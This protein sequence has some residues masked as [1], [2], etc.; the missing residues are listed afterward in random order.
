MRMRLAIISDTHFGDSHCALITRD[1]A[2]NLVR[3]A[4][5]RQ[6]VEAV[7]QVK[8]LVMAGDVFDF[9]VT[10]YDRAY[11]CARNFFQWLKD[12]GV[13]ER[14]VYLPGN[15]DADMWY[16]VLHQVH[17]I[18]SV[19]QGDVPDAF[20]HSVPAIIDDRQGADR[21]MLYGVKMREDSGLPYGGLFLDSLTKPATNFNF[22]FPNL[23]IVTDEETVLVTHGQY[24][25]P[26]WS[27]LGE[28]I[29]EVAAG[30]L[31]PGH[32]GHPR[33]DLDVDEIV[34]LNFPLNQLAC[35]GVGQAG[36]LTR[37]IVRPV[38][39][40][41][42]KRE[43]GRIERYLKGIERIVDRK[44]EFDKTL[45]GW[46]KEKW[47]DKTIGYAREWLMQEITRVE[48]ARNNKNFPAEEKER[49]KRYYRACL[50][51]IGLINETAQMNIPA[52]GRII[53]G[54]THE[55][56]GWQEKDPF[57]LGGI[58]QD[59]TDGR[60]TLHNTGGWVFGDEQ[61]NGFCAAEVFLYETGAGFSSVRIT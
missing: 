59:G 32:D 3:G 9:S 41:L 5:Y 29:T 60:V 46:I 37:Q 38:Q 35:T 47:S 34:Q 52:P 48:P 14:I 22:A 39:L 2:G 23:Y 7:G 6:L 51:E 28:I 57:R 50:N 20:R 8:Y 16:I 40:E 24:F 26:Y 30:D 54:H 56:F 27:C 13:A 12:D 53:Y 10:H 43:F 58:V 21:I 15:H 36:M 19:L 33:T 61:G 44:L 42:Q 45:L 17:V 31:H 4:R 18:N 11:E 49:I 1:S 55:P 25:E